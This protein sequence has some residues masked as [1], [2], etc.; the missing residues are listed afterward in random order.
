VSRPLVFPHLRILG[1]RS[2]TVAHDQIPAAAT[3]CW[4]SRAVS[5]ICLLSMNHRG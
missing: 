5:S 3:R 4:I 2:D 1:G